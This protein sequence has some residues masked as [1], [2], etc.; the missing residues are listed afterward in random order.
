MQLSSD[1]D[2][3]AGSM[4][5]LPALSFFAQFTYEKLKVKC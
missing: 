2:E 4:S 1:Y 3:S 5:E